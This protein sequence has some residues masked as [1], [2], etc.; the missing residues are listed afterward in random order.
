MIDTQK[1]QAWV[2]ENSFLF[3]SL[4]N[5]AKI[6]VVSDQ[7]DYAGMI[8]EKENGSVKVKRSYSIPWQ[9]PGLLLAFD[10]TT[11]ER[12]LESRSR[13][14]ELAVWDE[15]KREIGRGNV[16]IFLSAS[17]DINADKNG[18]LAFLSDLGVRPRI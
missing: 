2:N 4:K 13:D 5:E 10:E 3:N 18:Y 11:A 8:W 17:Y 7:K 9:K 1:W 14:G 6:G 15:F 16:R 12:L